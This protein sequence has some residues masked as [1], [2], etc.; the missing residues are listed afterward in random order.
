[1]L[2]GID[3]GLAVQHVH[4]QVVAAR[5]EVAVKKGIQVVDALDVI[6]AERCGDGERLQ[7]V[8]KTTPLWSAVVVI[9]Q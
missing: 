2:H 6:L 1:M 8:R 4:V 7:R 5:L 9:V 3:Q